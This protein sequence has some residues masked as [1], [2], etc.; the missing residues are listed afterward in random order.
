MSDRRGILSFAGMLVGAG[1]LG[2]AMIKASD[3]LG[4]KLGES[5]KAAAPQMA[6]QPLDRFTVRFAEF[7]D[8][9]EQVATALDGFVDL[10]NRGWPL[11][12][13]LRPPTK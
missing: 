13:F 6:S 3:K 5:L 7:C 9:V 10:A 4:D 8:P 2:F 11:R 1:V 12:P